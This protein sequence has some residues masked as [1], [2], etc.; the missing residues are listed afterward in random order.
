MEALPDSDQNHSL[1]AVISVLSTMSGKPSAEVDRLLQIQ[2][3]RF[4]T[5]E[6]AI[7]AVTLLLK[8]AQN[9]FDPLSPIRSAPTETTALSNSFEERQSNQIQQS[10][11]QVWSRPSG[12]MPLT[13]ESGLKEH[14][15]RALL[16]ESQQAEHQGVHY[17]LT[18]ERPYQWEATSTDPKYPCVGYV[19]SSYIFWKNHCQKRRAQG[20]P[21]KYITFISFPIVLMI[22]STNR[23]KPSSRVITM[24]DEELIK[25]LDLKFQIAQESN[26]LTKRFIVPPRPTKLASYELHIPHEDFHRYAT[27]WL[28]ELLVNQE[29]HKDLDKYDLSDVF[30]QSLQGCKMLYDHARVLSK[31]SVEDLIASCSEYL[32]EQVENEKKT[33]VARSC[34]LPESQETKSPRPESNFQVRGSSAGRQARV[35]VTDGN[36]TTPTN[37]RKSPMPPYL[38]KFLVA[39][40][41]ATWLDVGCEGC[42][43][44]YKQAVG[45]TFPYPCHGTCQYTGHPSMNKKYQE[46][47]KWKHQGFCCSWKGM[48]DKDI[49]APVLQRLQK[50]SLTRKRD[51]ETPTL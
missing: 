33:A 27:E 2:M 36:R 12:R 16:D 30:I 47:V 34:L 50:Y 44:W 15:Q 39:F 17:S 23:I 5:L 7:Q 22:T 28:A 26:L 18:L 21:Q 48:E 49:P 19:Q 45:K 10:S 31:L 42:G 24:S 40:V 41:K 37:D 46:G 9:T 8:P 29:R 13:E 25:I 38:P 14:Y 43:K 35:Y 51:R 4:K 11:L 6:D 3:A 20:A 1:E 32:G